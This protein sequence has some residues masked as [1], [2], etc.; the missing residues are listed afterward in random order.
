MTLLWHHVEARGWATGER[1]CGE[2]S[3]HERRGCLARSMLLLLFSGHAR[4]VFGGGFAGPFRWCLEGPTGPPDRQGELWM[5]IAAVE[6]LR[7]RPRRPRRLAHVMRS[8]LT[9]PPPLRRTVNSSIRAPFRA[10]RKCRPFL[11][12]STPR[13]HTRSPLHT[14]ISRPRGFT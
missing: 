2:S 7:R 14:N 6:K 10:V 12:V 11:A 5:K 3:S 13:P 1:A 9:V 8:K 4:G